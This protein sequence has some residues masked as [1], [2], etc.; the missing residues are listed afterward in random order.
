MGTERFSMF[1]TGPPGRAGVSGP[2]G[3]R[4]QDTVSQATGSADTTPIATGTDGT[5]SR[6]WTSAH[7][8]CGDPAPIVLVRAARERTL[9]R[10]A[11]EQS[12]LTHGSKRR[13]VSGKDPLM[14]REVSSPVGLEGLLAKGNG[15][16]R[17]NTAP[18]S[19]TSPAGA[20]TS[21][22][23]CSNTAR[24]RKPSLWSSTGEDHTRPSSWRTSSRSPEARATDR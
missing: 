4:M 17:T 14:G 8:E 21:F 24:A 9:E 13:D 1:S 15:H 23:Q 10:A 12:P 11:E 20:A 6:T 7:K 16:R 5:V 3:T 18:P 2:T 22:T 19:F